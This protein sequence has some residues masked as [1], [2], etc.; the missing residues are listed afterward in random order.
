M[1]SG[2]VI[3]LKISNSADYSCAVVDLQVDSDAQRRLAL[4]INFEA[5]KDEGAD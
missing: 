5:G 1:A 2:L 4:S 3:T